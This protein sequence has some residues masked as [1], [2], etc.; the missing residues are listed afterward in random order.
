MPLFH[1]SSRPAIH[2][3]FR[4]QSSCSLTA[5]LAS[6]IS[7]KRDVPSE[8]RFSRAH[9]TSACQDGEGMFSAVPARSAQI[10]SIA[11]SFSSTLICANG[12]S[13]CII[14]PQFFSHIRFEKIRKFYFKSR[15][16][17]LDYRS[18]RFFTIHS[19]Y[20][21]KDLFGERILFRC[22]RRLV[23]WT[24]QSRDHETDCCVPGMS[25]LLTG[26]DPDYDKNPGQSPYPVERGRRVAKGKGG[27]SIYA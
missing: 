11:C 13:K 24:L 18:T 16:N 22:R 4:R 17:C 15:I 9:N 8:M 23:S 19:T 5:F 12:M 27:A 10:S 7:R 25:R 6:E 1:S 20:T 14:T 2:F 3:G 26:N 21:F